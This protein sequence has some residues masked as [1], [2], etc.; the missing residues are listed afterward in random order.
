MAKSKG[1]VHGTDAERG[2]DVRLPPR[3]DKNA[4]PITRAEFDDHAKPLAVK[5]GDEVKVANIKSYSTGSLG[6]YAN[7]K[8]T[9]TVNGTP[10]K[11]QMQLQFTIVGSKELPGGPGGSNTPAAE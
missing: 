7:E 6:W 11:V 8:I 1:M 9:V 2:L 3:K 4:C 5:V 10:V